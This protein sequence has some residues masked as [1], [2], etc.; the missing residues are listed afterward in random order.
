MVEQQ[1]YQFETLKLQ[2]NPKST[3]SQLPFLLIGWGVS[4]LF[5]HH[6]IN[7]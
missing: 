1:I 5:A 2:T 6:P 3:G 7:E 4:L